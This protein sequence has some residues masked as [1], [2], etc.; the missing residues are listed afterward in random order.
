MEV[1]GYF[2]P[3][4]LSVLSILYKFMFDYIC[5]LLTLCE[6]FFGYKAKTAVFQMVPWGWLQ[7]A[8]Q[9]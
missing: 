8:S 3:A 4:F 9:W 7:K 5:F 6:N 1:V 2:S